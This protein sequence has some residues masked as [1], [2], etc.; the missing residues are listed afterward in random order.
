MEKARLYA[1]IE[2]EI[3]RS[4]ARYEKNQADSNISTSCAKELETL[5][6]LYERLKGGESPEGLLADL[7]RKLP[8]MKSLMDREAEFPSFDWYDEHYHYKVLDGQCDAYEWM[9]ALLEQG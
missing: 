1:K 9:I 3:A 8:E 7:R 2:D 4:R 5:R 6:Y